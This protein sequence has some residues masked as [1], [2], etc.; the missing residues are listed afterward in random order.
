M[1]LLICRNFGDPGDIYEQE[2]N[3]PFHP[4]EAGNGAE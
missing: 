2:L 3:G 1:A 4:V